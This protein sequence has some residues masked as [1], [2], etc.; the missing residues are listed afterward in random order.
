MANAP[1]LALFTLL[2]LAALTAANDGEAK[3]AAA[4]RGAPAKLSCSDAV[5]ALIPCGTYLLG[6][7]GDEPSS[8]CC[9]SAQALNRAAARKADRKSLCECLEKMGPSFNVNWQL[10]RLLPVYCKLQLTIPVSTTAN[11]SLA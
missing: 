1:S 3:A 5:T 7:S 2:A 6:S 9:R 11:C 4:V 8:E 10:A